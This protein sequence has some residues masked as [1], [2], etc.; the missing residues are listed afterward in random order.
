M[1]DPLR[2]LRIFVAMAARLLPGVRC[3]TA[4]TEYR[5]PSWRMIIPGRSCVAR[6]P[7]SPDTYGVLRQ[8]VPFGCDPGSRSLGGSVGSDQKCAVHQDRIIDAGARAGQRR[9]TATGCLMTFPLRPL[10]TA[11]RHLGF[12]ARIPVVTPKG[13]SAPPQIGRYEILQELGRVAVVVVLKA[14]D[15]FIGRLVAVKTITADF[16]ENPEFLERFRREAQAAGGLQ[17]P[18]IVTIYEMSEYE[19]TPF[20]AMEYLEG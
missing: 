16:S 6:I 19:G 9:W 13:T 4:C 14:K 2:R 18:N 11:R 5:S 15:P 8:A 20:I 1:I 12:L 17:H 7:F 3:S 10:A